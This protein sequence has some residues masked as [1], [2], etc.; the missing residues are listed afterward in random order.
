MQ[1]YRDIALKR[2][3]RDLFL[4]FSPPFS[5]AFLTKFQIQLLFWHHIFILL[6]VYSIIVSAL[7]GFIRMHICGNF[8]SEYF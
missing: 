7:T 2:F 5:L 4:T 6:F 3:V 8:N 1:R